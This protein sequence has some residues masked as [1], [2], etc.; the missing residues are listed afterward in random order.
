MNAYV[1]IYIEK[2]TRRVKSTLVKAEDPQHIKEI[3]YA[4]RI[5][6]IEEAKPKSGFYA[7][8]YDNTKTS[9]ITNYF[10]SYAD[11][12]KELGFKIEKCFRGNNPLEAYFYSIKWF[13]GV[14]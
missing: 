8:V 4:E 2:G 13:E 3:E 7:I 1:V 9:K 14:L 10:D 12:K 6:N 5:I 11:A